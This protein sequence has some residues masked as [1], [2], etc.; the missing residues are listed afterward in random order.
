MSFIIIYKIAQFVAIF[1]PLTFSYWLASRIADLRYYTSKRDRHLIINN[2]KNVFGKDDR[3]TRHVARCILRNFGKYLIE[4]LRFQKMGKSYFEK[5]V[6]VDGSE[7]LKEA[8]GANKGALL[9]SAHLGNW[10]WG[11]AIVAHLGFP[12]NAITLTHK[13]KR[14]DDF[15]INQRTIKG[16][17]NIPLGGSV[18]KTLR[19]LGKNEAVAI[20]S[21]RDFSNNSIPVTFFNKTAYMP[22]GIGLFAI[23]S[24]CKLVP[25][26]VIREK[27][28]VHRLI[29][30]KP[31]EYTLSGNKEEDI[32]MIVQK[33]TSVIEKYVRKYPEQWF[34]FDN[35][36][37]KN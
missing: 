21:D 33:T 20:L 27:N 25:T 12:L 23:K 7:N 18:R 14:V 2:L 9:F 34:M 37:R 8:L 30:E 10:E 31:L 36:W 16:I 19:V 17:K 1:F 3:H 11:A 24:N 32:K 6:L 35:P 4:F 5:Y 29:L 26:F 15:F 22:I 28:N 13:D